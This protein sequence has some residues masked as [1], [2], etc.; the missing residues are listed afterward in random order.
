MKTNHFI[1]FAAL[2]L[3]CCAMFGCG[4]E[5]SEPISEPTTKTTNIYGTV[6]NS[7]THEPVIGA[8]IEIGGSYDPELS[9]D[10]R[11]CYRFSSSVSGADGQYELHFGEVK[12]Y[13]YSYVRVTC[14]GYREYFVSAAFNYE[15]GANYQVDINLRPN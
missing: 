8:E 13:D 5:N 7:V 2:L 12:R 14:N 3:V 15:G 6:F 9:Y 4:K 1:K 11:W 10:Q